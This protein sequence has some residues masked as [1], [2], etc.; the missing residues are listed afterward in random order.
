[1]VSDL[2]VLITTHCLVAIMTFYSGLADAGEPTC[3]QEQIYHCKKAALSATSHLEEWGKCERIPFVSYT[4]VCTVDNFR[5]NVAYCCCVFNHKAMCCGYQRQFD[6]FR[7]SE[8]HDT[9]AD[10]KW[11]P[12]PGGDYLAGSQSSSEFALPTHVLILII[13]GAITL[14]A[15]VSILIVVIAVSRARRRR[16]AA[17]GVEG[18]S[19]CNCLFSEDN[20][21]EKPTPVAT[22]PEYHHE[23][24]RPL[25]DP[26]SSEPSSLDQDSETKHIPD[27]AYP[28]SATPTAPPLNVEDIYNCDKCRDQTT[29][30]PGECPYELGSELPS[31]H[32][33][34]HYHPH[35]HHNPTSGEIRVPPSYTAQMSTDSDVFFSP[36][37]EHGSPEHCGIN[38]NRSTSVPAHANP[39]IPQCPSCSSAP[40]PTYEDSLRHPVLPNQ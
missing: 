22:I 30:V 31:H 23:E 40:P 5:E 2:A 9:I 27:D 37:L 8:P 6:R 12:S 4:H 1:M 32:H 36:G 11:S 17:A 25:N 16:K 7:C 39:H 19:T 29:H 20:G 18:T 21:A 28:R 38:Y 33:H 13:A 15:I 14:V 26:M 3:N 24:R 34:S 35:H 10:V